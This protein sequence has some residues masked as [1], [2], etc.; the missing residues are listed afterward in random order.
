MRRADNSLSGKIT[1][2]GTISVRKKF[3]QA[4]AS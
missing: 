1:F 2:N 4:K 3:L